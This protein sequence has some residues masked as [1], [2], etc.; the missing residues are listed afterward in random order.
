MQRIVYLGGPVP[1][2][3]AVST[4]LASRLAVEQVLLEATPCSV[5]LRAS[6][7][8]GAR[9]RSFRFLVRLVERLPVMVLPAW[10]DNRT[11]PIDE[12]DV[13]ELLARAAT[14]IAVCGQSLDI[15]GADD[16]LLR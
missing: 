12:R 14:S 15:G 4:H 2:G 6:I 9:S 13:I 10:R 5:A 1:A 8:I 3:G 7:V 16:R 11:S